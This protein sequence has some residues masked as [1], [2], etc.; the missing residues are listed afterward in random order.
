MTSYPYKMALRN[1]LSGLIIALGLGGFCCYAVLNGWGISI[2]GFELPP[3]ASAYF[4]CFFIALSVLILIFSIKLITLGTR[5]IEVGSAAIVVPKSETSKTMVS[6]APK[7]ITD[8]RMDNYGE[9]HTLVIKH[10]GG[11]TKVRSPHFGSLDTF[12]EFSEL[13]DEIVGD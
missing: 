6:I 2:R 9:I 1:A 7:D 10:H 3:Q 11:T 8:L 4:Y 5:T 13:V 12:F